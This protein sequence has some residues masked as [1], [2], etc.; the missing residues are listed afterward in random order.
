LI[1]IKV[2]GGII[3]ILVI[4]GIYLSICWILSRIPLWRIRTFHVPL[5][6]MVLAKNDLDLSMVLFMIGLPLLIGSIV[7]YFIGEM[8]SVGVFGMLAILFLAGGLITN[9]FVTRRLKKYATQ[10]VTH[11]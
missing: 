9:Y 1:I 2:I 6:K 10:E 5:G 3:C 7:C 11:G 4:C 8:K